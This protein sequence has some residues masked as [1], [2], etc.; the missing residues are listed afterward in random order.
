MIAQ[1][2]N[3]K[4]ECM[5]PMSTFLESHGVALSDACKKALTNYTIKRFDKGQ[6]FLTEHQKARYLGFIIKGK[7]IHYYNIDGKHVTRW[8]SLPS[9]FVTAFVSF[10]NESPSLENLQCIEATELLL[11]E[12][13]YFMETLRSFQEIES[14][15]VRELENNMIGYEQRV[16]QL[17]TTNAET[18]YLNFKATYPQFEAEV[19]HKYIASMLGIEPRHLSR[20]RKKLQS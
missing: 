1:N 14:L 20:I 12:R 10:V 6:H 7:I 3:Q 17:I 2:S 13:N 18:R 15:W 9:T 11:F 19:P 4:V 8:V 16:H 5:N